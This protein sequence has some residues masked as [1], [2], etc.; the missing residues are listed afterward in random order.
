MLKIDEFRMEMEESKKIYSEELKRFAK[1]YDFLSE[2]T[3]IEE[4]DIDTID[5]IFCF[6]NL[7][8]TKDEILH[9]TSNEIYRHMVKFSESKG[10]DE[11]SKNA[12]IFINR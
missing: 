6:N 7:N 12:H 9:S 11:F 10:I 8:G 1:R 3:I 5:Y 4:P 2:F